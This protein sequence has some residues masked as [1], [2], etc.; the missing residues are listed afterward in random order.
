GSATIPTNV[1]TYQVALN[2]AA[3]QKIE[4]ANP[5][6]TFSASDFI[7][8][9]Y[10]INPV[11]T[12]SKDAETKV[13]VTDQAI[14]YGDATPTFTVAYGDKVVN[15]VA[16]TNADFTFDGQNSIPVDV[17]TYQVA[18]NAAAI[19]KIEEANPNY[20]FSA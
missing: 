12:D 11:A 20:T 7:G 19:Q 16:L 15:H 1:G 4:E 5:N 13:T 10:T 14:T 2:A 17:G 3:I 8:G 9:T 6:Y 18:L